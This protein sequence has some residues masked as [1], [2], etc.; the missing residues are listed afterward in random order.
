MHYST[1]TVDMGVGVTIRTVLR[2]NRCLSKIWL[3][4]GTPVHAAVLVSVTTNDR[5]L[6]NIAG[7]SESYG[8]DKSVRLRTISRKD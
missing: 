1:N 4:A 2:W 8:S 6:Q 3:Y 7:H 5:L